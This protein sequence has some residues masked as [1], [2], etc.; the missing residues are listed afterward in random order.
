M[1]MHNRSLVL[2]RLLAPLAGFSRVGSEAKV[3]VGGPLCAVEAHLFKVL[4]LHLMGCCCVHRH[5]TVTISHLFCNVRQYLGEQLHQ[6][7][8][9]VSPK[10]YQLPEALDRKRGPGWMHLQHKS[11]GAVACNIRRERI[12]P[13]NSV[14]IVARARTHSVTHTQMPTIEV[15]N[16]EES[17]EGAFRACKARVRS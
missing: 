15:A 12:E 14:I 1:H 8:S 13:A 9:R 11:A 4:G 16:L 10:T 7:G 3:D 6:R 5:L 17:E 2:E